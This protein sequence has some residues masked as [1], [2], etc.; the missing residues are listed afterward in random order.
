MT[1]PEPDADK[2]AR[3]RR[4]LERMP[5]RTLAIFIASQVERLSYVEI[6]RREHMALW[7]VRWHMRR[8]IRI[9]ASERD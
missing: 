6:A 9:I 1:T 5:A 4:T 8:A 7:Q 2:M 3:A